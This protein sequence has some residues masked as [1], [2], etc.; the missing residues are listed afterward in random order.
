MGLLQ[1]IRQRKKSA[2]SSQPTRNEHPQGSQQL[3]LLA[4]RMIGQNDVEAENLL[5]RSEEEM[6]KDPFELHFTFNA[7]IKLYK[8][9]ARKDPGALEKC[10]EYCTKD[11][12]LFPA[13]MESYVSQQRD[14]AGMDCLQ[15]VTL[16]RIPSFGQLVQIY[17]DQGRIRDAAEICRLAIYYGLHDREI[18][19]FEEKLEA[20]NQL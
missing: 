8:H 4:Q 11:I 3:W 15:Q 13:F 20:L 12:A 9:K 7:Y 18:G 10:I 1:F 6:Q 2:E 14:Q 16:P 17:E 19:S 5:R